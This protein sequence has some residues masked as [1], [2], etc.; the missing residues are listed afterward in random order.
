MDKGD[1][2]GS[3]EEEEQLDFEIERALNKI[4]AAADD[5]QEVR[6]SHRG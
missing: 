1:Q 5:K 4:E 2:I 3:N 6:V